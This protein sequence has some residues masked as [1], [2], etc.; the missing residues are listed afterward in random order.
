MYRVSNIMKG[1]EDSFVDIQTEGGSGLRCT[2][3]HPV[4]TPEGPV[5]ADRIAEGSL[6][7]CVGGGWQN[8]CFVFT[9]AGGMAYSLELVA[10][11]S[12]AALGL[13]D[14]PARSA[15]VFGGRHF[16]RRHRRPGRAR[17]GLWPALTRT[18][19]EPGGCAGAAARR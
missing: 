18:V 15:R 5:R 4:L 8:A 7:A 6:V 10:V 13:E 16:G 12:R 19:P 2:A 3:S 17:T 1:V 9:K 14:A 11:G